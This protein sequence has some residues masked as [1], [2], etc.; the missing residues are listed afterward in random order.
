MSWGDSISTSSS[1]NA[2]TAALFGEGLYLPDWQGYFVVQG[3]QYP[4]L[5]L[6][7]CTRREQQARAQLQPLAGEISRW[8]SGKRA[9][10]LGGEGR[11][12]LWN[13][14][15][16]QPNFINATCWHSFQVGVLSC[17]AMYCVWWLSKMTKQSWNPGYSLRT[18]KKIVLFLNIRGLS[19][20]DACMA[21]VPDGISQSLAS[22][23]LQVKTDYL[24]LARDVQL[25]D[26]S[27]AKL[28]TSNPR[29]DWMEK[30]QYGTVMDIHQSFAVQFLTKHL[31]GFDSLTLKTY[32][33]N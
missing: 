28:P 24:N 9:A 18:F 23:S 31:N 1:L 19:R 33:Y 8:R 29:Y 27:Q 14:R 7:P 4:C 25:R 2:G 15:L 13:P 11:I 16:N 30:E 17:T 21:Q 12:K 32:K 20:C 22:P 10:G 5:Y 6:R 26:S 3:L